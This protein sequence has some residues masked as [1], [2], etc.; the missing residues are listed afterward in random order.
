MRRL[1]GCQFGGR[2]AWKGE[3]KRRKLQGERRVEA[4]REVARLRV[5]VAVTVRRGVH[6]RRGSCSQRVRARWDLN[7]GG[8]PAGVL[9]GFGLWW[10]LRRRHVILLHLAVLG[11]FLKTSGAG[12]QRSVGIGAVALELTRLPLECDRSLVVRSSACSFVGWSLACFARFDPAVS[13]KSPPV[14][15]AQQWS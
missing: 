3:C 4:R 14:I 6:R 1:Y 5:V 2:V 9:A 12:D 13:G 11:R 7:C 8:G 15:Q 10:A